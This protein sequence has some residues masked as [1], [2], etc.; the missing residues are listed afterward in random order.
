[1][2]VY[3]FVYISIYIY[4]EGLYLFWIV[5]GFDVE[6]IFWSTVVL[7]C[8]FW[9]SGILFAMSFSFFCVREARHR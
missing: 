1:M 6:A 4:L 2:C 9:V 5:L 8:E 7:V 3:I